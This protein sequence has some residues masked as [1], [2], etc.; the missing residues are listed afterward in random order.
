MIYIVLVLTAI[1]AYILCDLSDLR[2][3]VNVLNRRIAQLESSKWR[4][5]GTE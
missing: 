3:R 4:R 1:V 5:D 2:N